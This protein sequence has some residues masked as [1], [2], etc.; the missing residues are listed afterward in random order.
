MLLAADSLGTEGGGRGDSALFPHL[1]FLKGAN[2]FSHEKD[3]QTQPH[4]H[5][6][7]L[8]TGPPLAILFL[9]IYPLIQQR[10]LQNPQV[11]TGGTVY[12][13]VEVR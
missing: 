10:F 9:S 11:K 13:Q 6:R 7:K 4:V 8:E 1:H 3:T 2:T 12:R 5:A